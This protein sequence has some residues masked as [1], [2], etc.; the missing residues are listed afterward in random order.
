LIL[1]IVDDW[2]LDIT[3]KVFDIIKEDTNTQ[4]KCEGTV[5]LFNK[6]TED[7]WY[8]NVQIIYNENNNVL[9][10]IGTYD[11]ASVTN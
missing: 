8:Y 9:R 4:Y 11:R 6:H 1:V 5:K 7:A 10:F 3:C 2:Y